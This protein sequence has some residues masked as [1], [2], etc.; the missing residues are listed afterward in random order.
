MTTPIFTQEK[1]RAIEAAHAAGAIIRSFYSTSYTV[2]YKDQRKDSPVTIADRD[3]NQ[4]IHDILQ[5]AFPQYGWLSEETVDSPERLSRQRVWLVD[6]LDGTKEFID[7]VPEFGVSIAL[8]ENGQPVVGVVYNPIHDQLFW[9]VR[10]QGAWYQEQRLQVTVTDRLS[11]ATILAS[12]SETKRGEW[13]KFNSQFSTRQ[14]GSAAYKLALIARGD[15]DATFTLT[16][17]NEW[18]I[19]AGVLLIEEAGGQV[20]HLDGRPMT[21]NQPKTLLQGLIASNRQLHSQLL[22]LVAK[23]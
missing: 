2:D 6:P 1:D 16:P 3:A 9:A 18:D 5:A 19:C 4:K 15:A 23:R 8:T 11:T 20:S 22:H 12:R 14:T 17:K 21:F 7:K 13:K 10:G